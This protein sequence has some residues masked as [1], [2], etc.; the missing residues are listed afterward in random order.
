MLKG[1]NKSIILKKLLIDELEFIKGNSFN[2]QY[3]YYI[4]EKIFLYI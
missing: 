4:T 3:S 1:P 2:A